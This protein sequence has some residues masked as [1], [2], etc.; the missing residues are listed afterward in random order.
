[1]LLGSYWSQEIK[2]IQESNQEIKRV[3]N[4]QKSAVFSYTNNEQTLK[5]NFKNSIYNIIKNNK[6][7]NPMGKRLLY[8]K[9]NIAERN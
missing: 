1:M 8:W 4:T 2:N 3:I 6:I 9:Q 5:G 7:L